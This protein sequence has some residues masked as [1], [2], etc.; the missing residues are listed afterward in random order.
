VVSHVPELRGR[1]P[2]QVQVQRGRA[3]STIEVC[4]Q[5]STLVA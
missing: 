2:T 5:G 3:G 1:I 4:G